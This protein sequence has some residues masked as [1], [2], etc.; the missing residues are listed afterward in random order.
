MAE[1]DSAATS[2]ERALV[3][4][5]PSNR[6]RASE[7]GQLSPLKL[8]VASLPQLGVGIR[9]KLIGVMVAMVVLIV[10]PLATYFPTHELEEFRKALHDRADV[11]AA[12]TSQQLRSAIAFDDRETAREVVDALAKD[13]V[14][15]GVAVYSA[16]GQVLHRAGSLS[17]VANRVG[18]VWKGSIAT[19]DLPG[20][21]L[22]VAP[23]RSLEGARGILVLEL[24]TRPLQ[25]TQRRLVLGALGIGA[26]AL[27]CGGG[28]AWL[29]A[30]SLARR[31]EV[32]AHAASAMGRGELDEPIVVTG[33]ND[34]IG[35]L[36]HGFN[37]MRAKVQELVAH[38][39]Q[40]GRDES[41][42]LERLVKRRTEQLD[43]MN[44]DLRLVLDNVEQGF[45]TID[46]EA[47]VVG[48]Y[49]RI[50]ETW[51]GPLQ[52]NQCF[53]APLTQKQ[54]DAE[55][56]F[57]VGWEQVV[58]SLMPIEA[59]LDQLPRRLKIDDRHLSLEYRPLG[60]ETFTRLLV[61]ITDVT[62]IVAREASEQEARDLVNLTLKLLNDRA[63]FLEFVAESRRLVQQISAPHVDAISLRRDVHTLKGNAALYGLSS[64]ATACH[65]L[66]SALQQDEKAAAEREHLVTCWE[67]CL[68]TIERLLGGKATSKIEIDEDQYASLL[69]AVEKDA[70]R[71][72]LENALKTWR[73]EPLRERLGRAAEQLTGIAHRLGG[74]VT[75]QVSSPDIYVQREELSEFWGA[76]SHVLRNAAVHGRRDPG[77]REAQA[78]LA[79]FGLRAGIEENELFVELSDRGP[80]ID[81]DGIRARATCQGMPHET[82]ADLEEAL[83]AD[84]ISTREEVSELAGRGVGLSAVRAAC[85]K[86]AG[87][88][89]VTSRRGAGTSFRFS[90]PVAQFDSL[91]QLASRGA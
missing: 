76:F 79:D 57:S 84:G 44:Q 20:R 59:T 27:L 39:Q 33:P 5:R 54:P 37:A 32:I 1:R 74:E 17:E 22:A 3:S 51:L 62:A 67:R 36:S 71:G 52:L 60:G 25:A 82:Q 70:P 18:R 73:L 48:A 68:A 30:R 78:Q 4:A 47:R 34:E 41:A 80:G 85:R 23:I 14:L 13:P 56:A 87:R 12:L 43:V 53:W 19:Y 42:R 86:R 7:G 2:Q 90:W 77:Q 75:V 46:R 49:S 10:C 40:V 24:S 63:G 45:V 26:A 9:V 38:I 89:R 83:F 55:L 72:E 50:I 81:W 88:I 35:L 58:D 91:V 21:I 29:I 8:K 64:V 16:S 69:A 66:E 65:L 11:Y 28:V 61:V 15:D 6:A 31:I